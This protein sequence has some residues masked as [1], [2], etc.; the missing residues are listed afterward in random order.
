MLFS[1]ND[2]SD[3]SALYEGENLAELERITADLE[4][5]RRC[6]CGGH[7]AGVPRFQLQPAHPG[8]WHRRPARCCGNRR[9]RGRGSWRRRPD[10]PCTS[11]CHPRRRPGDRQPGVQ[12]AAALRQ[13]RIRAR[14]RRPRRSATGRAGHP[15]VVGGHLPQRR[16]W[17]G[18]WHRRRRRGARWQ[19]HARRADG[20]HQRGARRARRC[21]VRRV[22]PDRHRFAGVPRRDQRL[23]PGRHAAPRRRCARPDGRGA[24]ADLPGALAPACHCCRC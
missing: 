22:R 2:G 20:G 4:R 19:R 7:P 23:P 8:R 24:G 5:D 15:Q 14:G 17:T 3:V 9:G 16:G 1:S 21:V 11:Q 12:P 13:Q 18:Q 6:L 10:G